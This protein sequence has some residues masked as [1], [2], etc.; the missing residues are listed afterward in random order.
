MSFMPTFFSAFT[1]INQ[2]NFANATNF[3]TNSAG[4][5]QSIVQIQSNTA[6]ILN[7]FGR[8]S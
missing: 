1:I 5:N 4:L 2:F 8:S 7:V 3:A 6:N